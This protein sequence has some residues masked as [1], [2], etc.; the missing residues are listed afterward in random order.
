MKM[1]SRCNHVLAVAALAA[2]SG[3]SSN[4]VCDTDDGNYDVITLCPG[5]SRTCAAVPCTVYYEMPDGSGDYQVIGNG[6]R[7][8]GFP[9]GEKVNLGSYWESYYFD[10]EGANVPRSYVF[11]GETP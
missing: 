5:A 8:G 1:N 2:L 3:C 9:A 6:I 11:I 4:P 10:I 7:I